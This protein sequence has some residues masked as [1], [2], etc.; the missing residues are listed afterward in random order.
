MN[1]KMY[2]GL[3]R[4]ANERIQDAKDKLEAGEILPTDYGWHI[5]YN[6]NFLDL[7]RDKYPHW[8]LD[9]LIDN[10]KK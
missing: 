6:E 7:L 5:Q 10:S 3:I 1:K 8:W 2:Y 9:Y 4:R